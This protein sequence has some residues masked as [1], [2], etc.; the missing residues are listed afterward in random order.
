M[1]HA[2]ATQQT[3]TKPTAEPAEEPAEEQTKDES[4]PLANWPQ[5][6]T[7]DMENLVARISQVPGRT[8]RSGD[9]KLLY[10][11]ETKL[12]KFIYGQE[13][14]IEQLVSAIQLS[15][16]GLGEANK[17]VGA[18]LFAGPTGV[19][20]TELAKKLAEFLGVHF[21]RFDMSEY[22][23]KHTVSRLLGSPPGYVGFEQ[24]GQ[25]TENIRRHPHCVLLLD[26]IEKAHEDL[27]N[28]LLQVMDYAT[29]TDNNNRKADFRNVILIM[30]TNTGA[31][32][33][34][35]N[36]IGFEAGQDPG[37]RSLEAIK[38]LFSPEF[39]NRL[40]GI[41]SFNN[42]QMEQI[43]RIVDKKIQEL[44]IRL[45][46]K[47][48]E[49][50]L[51]PEARDYLSRKGFDKQ[52]GARPIQRLIESEIAHALSQEILFGKLSQGGCVR[53]ECQKDSLNFTYKDK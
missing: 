47:N 16:A 46:V 17:P 23:E 51:S 52:Y 42:L 29:L 25:L 19:G 37:G 12:K 3:Q 30:T 31:R 4:A 9:K 6:R 27:L 43:Q 44:A 10:G 49:L 14:A 50:E 24:G 34:L 1:R 7:T 28:V 8:V 45:K 20:K 53:I 33:S 21:H 35:Q 32:E 40:S 2:E 18:F 41:I 26:E 13:A 39:R 15:R 22:M 48:I 5:V 36:S 38:K 11:L